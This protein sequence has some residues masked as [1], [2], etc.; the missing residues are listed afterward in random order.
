MHIS[1]ERKLVVVEAEGG[2]YYR[3]TAMMFKESGKLH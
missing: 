1:D 3:S 2:K